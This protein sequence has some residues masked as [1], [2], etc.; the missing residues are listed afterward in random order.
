ME[1]NVGIEKR[2][3]GK[4]LENV[5]S[6]AKKAT[7]LLK[8]YIEF[9]MIGGIIFLAFYISVTFGVKANL[10]KSRATFFDLEISRL[11]S[12][13]D[14]MESKMKYLES[15]ATVMHEFEKYGKRYR[16]LGYGQEGE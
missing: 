4:V 13:I 15:K 16:I 3:L 8:L 14:E 2:A 11:S 6:L 9:V 7:H 5:G 12:E 10:M 1:R